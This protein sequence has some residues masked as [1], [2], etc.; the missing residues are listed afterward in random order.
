MTFP[1][2]KAAALLRALAE[3]GDW[4]AALRKLEVTPEEGRTLLL[5]SADK[6]EGPRA[7]KRREA[8]EAAARGGTTGDTDSTPR[9]ATRS[10]MT[11][12]SVSPVLPARSE[13]AG[14]HKVRVYCDGASRG[15][16]GLAG[17]G[18]VI[19][20]ES[21]R[22]LDELSRFLGRQ[23]NNFAEYQG[24]LL[25]LDRAAALGAREVDVYAD[26]ELIVRQMKGEY[27][28]KHPG[29]RPLHEEARRRV[30]GFD[31]VNF[32]HIPREMNAGADAMSNRAIDER[33]A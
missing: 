21:G 23:T 9:S 29:L 22:V 17:A 8:A 26:S 6:L 4:Q 16:P 25:G 32:I 1:G 14:V 10:P 33:S 28:V 27:R 7:R 30:A 24:L 15:N 20:D 12:R 18:A 31:A 3:E 19:T 13:G 5:Q 11:E 2:E